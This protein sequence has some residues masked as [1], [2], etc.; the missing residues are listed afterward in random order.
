[1][2]KNLLSFCFLIAFAITSYIFYNSQ[3]T[4][5]AVF[6][7][8]DGLPKG[9]PVTALGVK[10]G[11][12]IRTK[13]TKDG[14]KVTVRIT[15]KSFSRPEGGSQ[16]AI[17]SF[18]PG[19][20]RVLEII[21]TNEKLAETKAWIIQEPITAE[22]WWHAS[23]DILDGLENF[24]KVAIKQVTPENFTKVRTVL[25]GTSE[26]LNHTAEH[27][28]DYQDTLSS[29]EQNISSHSNEASM[30]LKK[31]EKSIN[32]S[33][34]NSKIEKTKEEIKND[35]S[36][37]SDDLSEISANVKDAKF[38]K[39]L[40]SYKT[41]FQEYLVDVNESLIG[42]SKKIADPEFKENYKSFNK[43]ISDINS[44]LSKI[45]LSEEKRNA[46]KSAISK[47]KELTTKTAKSTQN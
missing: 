25:K 10:V 13:P 4:F 12:V 21:P 19:Q 9:A 3:K 27:L 42:E 47:L 5:E 44:S 39:E 1:M 45:N 34:K 23:I 24:S 32:H 20:G 22:S 11:E 14:I 38:S 8:V 6:K 33:D 36:D 29:L 16:L 7:H 46:I 28:S 37:F 26:S 31:L 18:R 41:N 2:I 35:L 15:R 43:T 40:K 30:L 17:T